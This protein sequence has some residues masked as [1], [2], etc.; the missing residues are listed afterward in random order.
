MVKRPM[1]S[2]Q[3]LYTST[4]VAKASAS[5]TERCAAETHKTRLR[6]PLRKRMEKMMLCIKFIAGCGARQLP[7]Q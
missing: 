7:H 6:E 4:S 1:R 3:E 5:S 2:M